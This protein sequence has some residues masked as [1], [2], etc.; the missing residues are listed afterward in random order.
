VFLVNSN[1]GLVSREEEDILSVSNDD[2]S[3]S[4]SDAWNA[5]M[6]E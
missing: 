5:D 3:L 1:G 6:L 4:S 2:E